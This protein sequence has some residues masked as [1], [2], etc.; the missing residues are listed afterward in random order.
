M[1]N[2]R[3]I[4]ISRA[5]PAIGTPSGPILSEA[6]SHAGINPGIITH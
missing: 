2:F 3:N 1:K 4:P 6:I 5:T